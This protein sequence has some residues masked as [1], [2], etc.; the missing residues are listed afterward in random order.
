MLT[1]QKIMHAAKCLA[2]MSGCTGQSDWA[3]HFVRFAQCLC[4]FIMTYHIKLCKIFL[5]FGQ[6]G[7]GEY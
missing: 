4:P 2:R 5:N 7:L 3:R 1:G 6:T